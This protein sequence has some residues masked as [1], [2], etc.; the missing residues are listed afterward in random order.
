MQQIRSG[1]PEFNACWLAWAAGIAIAA[2]AAVYI[3]K[4]AIP[5]VIS[6]AWYYVDAFVRKSFEGS[7]T[8]G[9]FFAKRTMADHSLPFHKLVMLA[10]AH[11]FGLDLSKEAWLGFA[12]ALAGVVFF[13][14]VLAQSTGEAFAHWRVQ[15]AWLAATAVYLS[16]NASNIFEWP[17]ITLSYA[18]MFFS[19]CFFVACRRTVEVGRWVGVAVGVALVLVTLDNGGIIMVFAGMFASILLA[20]RIGELRRGLALTVGLLGAI[21]A[22]KFGYEWLAPS[23]DAVPRGPGFGAVLAKPGWFPDAVAALRLPLTSAVLHPMHAQPIF[24]DWAKFTEYG[25]AAVAVVAHAC[26]WVQA[27]TRTPSPARH[28]A[29]CLMLAF[30]GLTAGVLIGR[31]PELGFGVFGQP[32]YVVF[33]QL[34]IVALCL[35]AGCAMAERSPEAAA[36]AM[37]PRLQPVALSILCAL[38]LLLQ[39]PLAREGWMRAPYQRRYVE[40]LAEQMDALAAAPAVAPE[41]CLPPLTVCR[42][43]PATRVRAVTF[44][45]THGLNLFSDAFRRRHAFAPA[46]CL[47][48]VSVPARR[49]PPP[50]PGPCAPPCLPTGAC[51]PADR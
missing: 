33:Y 37:L 3:A 49:S 31:V 20:W 22:Y 25:I 41:K 27:L 12:F 26:F 30:Y 46:P 50:A 36:T 40:R 43:T 10:D 34:H 9:D 18:T 6:D 47:Q 14:R 28:F 23:P 38:L 16:L 5:L 32:R 45:H 51:A 15:L 42:M 13:R 19:Y 7:L 35:M 17:M 8:F 24:G 29:V 21:A 4:V 1:Q 11:W 2:H 48:V 39:W 44:L